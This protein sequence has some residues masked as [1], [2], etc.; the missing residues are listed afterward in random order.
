MTK[1]NVHYDGWIALPSRLRQ[2]LR[3][4]AGDELEAEVRSGELILRRAGGTSAAEAGAAAPEPVPTPTGDKPAPKRG[5]P[6]KIAIPV[7]SVKA[8]FRRKSVEAPPKRK[9]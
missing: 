8:A 4:K 7:Q 2:R 6:R 9:P 3:L 5:R 1:I